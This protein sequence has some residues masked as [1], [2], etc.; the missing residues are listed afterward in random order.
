V[1]ADH[2]NA[3]EPYG[4]LWRQNY[5]PV[6]EAFRLWIAGV[7]NVGWLTDG[8][9]KGQKCIGCSLVIGPEG[10]EILQGPYGADAEAILHVDIEPRPR[11]AWGCGWE[12]YWATRAG[13]YPGTEES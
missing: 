9:W 7:S 1:P 10:Q 11:P 13:G 12:T 4:D 8:P 3:R 2:D 6:A 5:R